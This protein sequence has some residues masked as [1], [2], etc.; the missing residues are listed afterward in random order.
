[1][2]AAAGNDIGILYMDE[3]D[4]ALDLYAPAHMEALGLLMPY[5]VLPD[6]EA[7]PDGGIGEVLNPQEHIL[8]YA[9]GI[10]LDREASR[11]LMDSD[12]AD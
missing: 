3:L 7:T 5:L 11:P 9:A 1:M 12:G 2:D 4:A 6:A 8:R 10:R